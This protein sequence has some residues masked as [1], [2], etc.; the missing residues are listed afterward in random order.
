MACVEALVVGRR[1]R[2]GK[3][4][5][6]KREFNAIYAKTYDLVLYVSRPKMLG[7]EACKRECTICHQ[8][9]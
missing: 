9:G 1:K 7:G 6:V 5:F 3:R 4:A 2:G 8:M